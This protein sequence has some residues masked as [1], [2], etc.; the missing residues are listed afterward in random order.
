[1]KT[2]VIIPTY[3]RA[4]LVIKAVLSVIE[5][6]QKPD[7]IIVVDDG[8]TDNT[9]EVLG[10]FKGQMRYIRQLNQGV[11]AARNTG[12][13]H[14]HSEW[15]CFLDSDD[16][17]KP[18]K[19]AEQKKALESQP[20]FKICYTNEIWIKNGRYLNQGK[21]H[22]KYG[23]WIYEKCLPLCIISPSSVM[24]H[25]TVLRYTGLFDES[26]RAC[27]DYDLW[28]R[29][30]N[31]FPVLYIPDKLI[32]KN[33][34]DWPQL[35]KQHS[36]DKLRI[37]ALYKMLKHGKLSR[38]KQMAT[39]QMLKQKCNIYRTGCLHHSKTKDIEWIDTIIEKVEGKI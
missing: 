25:R 10:R 4:D 6:K 21:K 1:M 7:E 14:S 30:T 24:L 22:T 28:L 8:S 13:R 27:E 33:A 39:I 37:R 32:T 11:S 35:S 34:G 20:D 36:L 2:C 26:M 3:N 9:E 16:L 17:W 18:A 23:G 5:Q 38:S 15:I 31:L 12:I 29:V 19:L